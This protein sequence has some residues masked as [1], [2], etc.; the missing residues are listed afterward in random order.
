[1]IASRCNVWER[2]ALFLIVGTEKKMRNISCEIFLAK[3]FLSYNRFSISADGLLIERDY[4]SSLASTVSRMKYV[5]FDRCS[6]A[7]DIMILMHKSHTLMLIELS[8]S[9]A[10]GHFGTWNSRG[11]NAGLCIYG[12]ICCTAWDADSQKQFDVVCCK[13][14]PLTLKCSL[15]FFLSLTRWVF[16]IFFQVF[17]QE[18][19]FKWSGK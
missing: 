14:E 19:C 2:K 11:M 15:L 9:P 3:S 5:M 16:N 17:L 1:M 7:L 6:V 13:S 18:M 12:I 8:P 4:Y 10:Q